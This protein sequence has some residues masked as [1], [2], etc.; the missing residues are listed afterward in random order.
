MSYPR[1]IS[2]KDFKTFIPGFFINVRAMKSTL[3]KDPAGGQVQRRGMSDNLFHAV[4][5]QR[6]FDKGP[7]YLRCIPQTLPSGHQ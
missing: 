3:F 1:N 6:V 4:I 2:A 7:A 5:S